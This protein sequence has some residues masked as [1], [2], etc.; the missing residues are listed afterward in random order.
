MPIE[1]YAVKVRLMCFVAV[2][3]VYTSLKIGAQAQ[4][5]PGATPTPSILSPAPLASLKGK[6]DPELLQIV[7]MRTDAIE[8]KKDV[9][10]EDQVTPSGLD[11]L[12][13]MDPRDA[14]LA[15]ARDYVSD[16][17]K[18]LRLR[19]D[20]R[21]AKPPRSGE[22]GLRWISGNEYAAPLHGVTILK[23]DGYNSEL[24]VSQVEINGEASKAEIEAA[25]AKTDSHPL[26]RL[27]AQQTYEI[28]WWLRH[29]RKE[30]DASSWS[31][32]TYS[33]A[34]DF[35]RFWM[36]PDG[37]VIEKALF[38]S[39]CGQCIFEKDYTSY[40]SFAATL[41]RRLIE[42][43][44]IKPRHPTPTIGKL[45]IRMMTRSF[46]TSAAGPS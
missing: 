12:W 33:S 45:S 10:N 37:P 27:V 20:H 28:I 35:G 14:A 22:I 42:R 9:Y 5:P 44:G 46:F 24:L 41:I 2:I 17:M 29:V 32:A 43:I 30:K 38:G 16:S 34:D 1:F 31:S 40:E 19:I 25:V 21:D 4:I 3:S 7:T 36:K 6:S 8:T 39:P 23:Y 18:G 11:R 13:E 15:F 26:R